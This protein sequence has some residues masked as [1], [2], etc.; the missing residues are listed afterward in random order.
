MLWIQQRIDG[1]TLAN[2]CKRSHLSAACLHASIEHGI[3]IFVLV[4][5]GLHGSAL[6]LVRLQ[7]EAYIRGIWLAECATNDT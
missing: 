6:A 3:A 2:P 1:L 5:D 4:N 7:L